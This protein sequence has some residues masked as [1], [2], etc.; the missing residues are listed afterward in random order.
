MSDGSGLRVDA[1]DL[2]RHPLPF[3]QM[4]HSAA[5]L[6]MVAVTAHIRYVFFVGAD[7]KPRKFNWLTGVA[8]ITLGVLEGPF[9]AT[10][11]GTEILP[12]S[13]QAEASEA[14]TCSRGDNS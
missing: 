1:A 8:L 2:A 11:P 7:R 5:N 10:C 9:G 13:P 3:R 6:F 12:G 4:H 14:A